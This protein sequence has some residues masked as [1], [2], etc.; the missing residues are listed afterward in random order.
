ML[1]TDVDDMSPEYVEP[2]RQ[3]LVAVGALDVQTWP[4]QMKKGRQ[5]F[6][7][8]VMA[9]EA[10]ADVV[11]AELFRHS[12]TAGVRRWIAERATLPRHQ[13]T[14]RL[15]GV[16]VRVKVLGGGSVRV[17]PEYDDVLAA[18]KALGR[19]PLDVAR[20]VE[21]DAEALIAKPKE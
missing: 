18:A 10:L 20:A 19:P 2:L 21:R 1:A 16:A 9:P 15:D 4:V 11:T 12:T 6:R 14:V 13:L 3:A 5:G 7:V 8:E 17:K